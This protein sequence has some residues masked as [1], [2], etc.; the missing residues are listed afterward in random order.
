MAFAYSYVPYS[1][2]GYFSAL[3][4]DYTE[5]A[6][7]AAVFATYPPTDSGMEAAITAREKYPVNRQLLADTL[8][9]QYS[10]LPHHLAVTANIDL[11]RQDNTYT[12]CTAHQPNLM[13]GYLYFIYKILHA[14]QLAEQLTAQYPGKNF[15]PVYYM[16]SEDNDLEELGKF[17][18][19][20]DLYTWDAAGQK[21]A[22]GRM[23]TT[24]LQPLLNTLFKNFGPPGANCDQLQAMLVTAYR[25]HATIGAATQYL[26]HELFGRYGLVVL[27]PDDA[28]FKSTFLPVMEDELLQQHAHTIIEAQSE[29]L[30]ATY[31]VQAYPREINLFYLSHQVRERIQRTGDTWQVL[32]TD[33]AWTKEAL[34][35][36]LHEHPERFSPNVMLRGLYQETIMPNVAF[37]GGGAE[38]A[39]WLQ[40]KTLFQHYGVFYPCLLLRQSVQWVPARENELR[41]SLGIAEHELFLPLHELEAAYITTH[42]STEWQA[43]AE[44]EAMNEVFATLSAKAKA[45]DATLEPAAGAALTKMKHQLQ[46]LE[47]KML[48]A[49]KRKQEVG[50]AR[51]ARLK[52]ALFP[53]GNLQERVDNFLEYYL[54][55]GPDFLDILKDGI[56]PLS[57]QF[58]VVSEV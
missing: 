9:K 48:R 1:K 37:I 39:Y 52:A 6:P 45:V 51:L 49:E 43:Q 30:A 17:R 26:V 27:D 21:G 34:L 31:K 4:V 11:L 22:V 53:K 41:S 33:I 13:T 36:E 2:T 46:V 42:A 28:A 40:L 38:I 14:I 54:M 29:Q 25:E 24:S 44:L 10:N 57:N 32:N 19:R 35:A 23:D 55:H 20:G 15:V 3:A 8:V 58:L 56:Q 5:V 47:Q 7:G 16:G 50:M 12:I 18:F